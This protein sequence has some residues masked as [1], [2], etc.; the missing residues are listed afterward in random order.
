MNRPLLRPVALLAIGILMLAACARA[1][2]TPQI[3]EVTREVEMEVTR[4]V[5]VTA[6]V[7]A[8]EAFEP[9]TLT[10]PVGAGLE[11]TT[12]NAFFPGLLRVRAGD[13]VTWKLESDELHTVSFVQGVPLEQLTFAVP[14]P[15]GAQG[16]LMANPMIAFPTRFPGAPV[17]TYSGEG[18]VSSGLMSK[19]APAPNVPPNDAFSLTFDT[20]GTYQYIC[21]VHEEFMVAT[22]V[23][24]PATAAD[25]PSQDEIDAQ[26]EAEMAPILADL[27]VSKQAGG[28]AGSAP[29]PNDTTLWFV[30]AGILDFVTADPRAESLEFLPKNLTVKSGDTVIWGSTGFHTIT[31][32]PVAPPPEFII[33]EPQ[34]AGPPLLKINPEAAI[35]ARPA[36][37]YDPT[38]YY[39]SGVVGIFAPDGASWA[40][41][42]DQPGTYEYIC[43]VHRALGMKGTITV[44][45]P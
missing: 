5:E 31:F 1:T 29:G 35:P 17:E 15:G 32:D 14:V 27:E 6:P 13:T 12:F 16:E 40:L 10:A 45:A 21:L 8:P 18:F 37:V 43:I 4:V 7:P 41:T 44:E 33:P 39:N 20:A 19:Q 3:V 38:Q 23:V 26:A 30:K 25:G 22:V 42:F 28:Q 11:T 34:Q 2:P 24:E 36:A 9:R